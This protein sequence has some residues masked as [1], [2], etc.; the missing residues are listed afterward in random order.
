MSVDMTTLASLA[1]AVAA[2]R[3]ELLAAAPDSAS[4]AE[5]ETYLMR[6]MTGCLNDAFLSHLLTTSG[7]TRALPTK[8]APNP[9]YLVYHAGIDATRC[10]QLT[11]SLNESERVGVGLYS[12]TAAG[13]AVLAGYAS[14]DRTSV[15]A[16]GH[17]ALKLAADAVGSGKLPITPACRV[18]I[19][20]ILHRDPQGSPCALTL[21]GGVQRNLANATGAVESALSQA[22]QATLR[23]VKQ[24]I[25]W[26]RQTSANPNRFILPP[27]GMAAEVQGDPDT[28]YGLG[29]YHLAAGEW[30]EASIPPQLTGYWSLHAYNH[31]CES[32]PGTGIHDR[33]AT[34][35]PDGR[36]RVHIG[37]TL[38]QAIS[39]RIDTMAR[40]RGVLIFRAIGAPDMQLPRVHVRQR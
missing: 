38:P 28:V 5:A 22:G 13:M 21:T 23:G 35:D 10:Y 29:Y 6:V 40:Q 18:V 3:S 12:F 39:N 7:L 8:G 1:S 24:F 27:P 26:S 19:V 30:L 31:W 9:D 34:R 17:F 4:A 37:P 33:N 11:G 20:R 32:L 16:D 15:G 25:E 2:A 14:F 36:I